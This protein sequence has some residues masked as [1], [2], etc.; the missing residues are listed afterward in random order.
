MTEVNATNHTETTSDMMS[1]IPRNVVRI[2]SMSLNDMQT[3]LF[4]LF[5]QI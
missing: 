2:F 5:L 4:G 1:T 3:W